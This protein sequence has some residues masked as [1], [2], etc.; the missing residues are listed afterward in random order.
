MGTVLHSPSFRCLADN[1]V[2]YRTISACMDLAGLFQIRL[3][4]TSIAKSLYSFPWKSRMT[5]WSRSIW[6]LCVPVSMGDLLNKNTLFFFSITCG[7]SMTILCICLMFLIWISVC[8]IVLSKQKFVWR[9]E[10]N[11]YLSVIIKVLQTVKTAN[12]AS[13]ALHHS[14]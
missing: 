11:L 10:N 1:V 4:L 9:K 14:T 2:L 5:G 6:L 8:T 13:D 3:V 7:M 12:D